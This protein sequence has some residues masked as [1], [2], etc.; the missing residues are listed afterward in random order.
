[1]QSLEAIFPSEPASESTDPAFQVLQ[2]RESEP[3]SN[4][5]LDFEMEAIKETLVIE[6]PHPSSSGAYY[7]ATADDVAK[8]LVRNQGDFL[9]F[10]NV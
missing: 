4:R 1:M 7:C 5:E 9:P 2:Q 8:L 6:A 10:A 3:C